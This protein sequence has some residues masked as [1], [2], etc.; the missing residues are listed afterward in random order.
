MLLA[1]L[2]RLLRIAVVVLQR[3]FHRQRSR[4]VGQ[5]PVGFEV[6]GLIVQHRL[7]AVQMLDELRDAAAVQELV[8]LHRVHALIGQVDLQALVQ[9]RQLAQP[10]RQRVVI[11]G[12]FHHDRGIR[13]ERDARAGFPAG[14]ARPQQR[15]FGMAAGKFHLPGI[16]LAPDFQLQPLGERVYA[17]HAHAMQ[18]AR[19]LV[20]L[21]IELAAGVQLGHHDF[22]GRYA[23]L[24]HIH[25]DAA[26]VVDHRYG[27]I[28]MNRYIHLRAIAGQ[29]FVHGIVHHLVNQVMQP[30]L[31][32]RAD[33]HGRPEA[34]GLQTFQNLDAA[35]IVNFRCAGFVQRRCH[36]V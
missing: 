13:L 7:P 25:R 20:A 36:W 28:D 3:D 22:R 9:E 29:G 33:I 14:F 27:I 32:S 18:S 23:F 4:V 30:H 5:F 26:A 10:L 21:G 15:T 31:A 2:K 1:K 17:A 6:D 19:Y 16:T 11:V 12:G 8:V 34:Y 24:V 35:G